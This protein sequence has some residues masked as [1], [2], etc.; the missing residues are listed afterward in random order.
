MKRDVMNDT[1]PMPGTLDEIAGRVASPAEAS[2]AG[3]VEGELDP[4]T[5]RILRALDRPPRPPAPTPEVRASSDGGDFVAY[6]SGAHAPGAA[7]RSEEERRRQVLAELS[8]LIQ[9]PP[10]SE[11]PAH[12]STTTVA[13]R[14]R[15]RRVSW[16]SWLVGILFLAGAMAVWGSLRSKTVASSPQLPTAQPETPAPAETTD[17]PPPTESTVASTPKVS[18][19]APVLSGSRLPEAPRSTPRPS[20]AAHRGPAVAASAAAP[21]DD[22]IEHPW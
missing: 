6:S 21:S 10:T 13:P 14:T 16:A 22:L 3:E 17:S 2:A 9:E 19:I 1:D 8:V 7:P 12:G 11:T 5:A 4:Q 18:A 15:S 20:T